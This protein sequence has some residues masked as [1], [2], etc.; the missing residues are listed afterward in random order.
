MKQ[1]KGF[2]LIE[3]MV[4]MTIM[5]LVL[6]SLSMLSMYVAIRGRDNDG[7]AKR[8][9]ALQLEANKFGA[10]PYSTLAGWNTSNASFTLGDFR[11]TRRLTIT[12][13]SSSRYTIKIVVVP[14]SSAV[15]PDSVI[16]DRTL[17]ST[18]GAL[19]TGC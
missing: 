15:R 9:A 2:S 13:L 10:V 5:S 12:T 17:P 6:M 8:T 7:A 1:R 11:Y 16:L 3:I 14:S 19:C 18:S 4:A